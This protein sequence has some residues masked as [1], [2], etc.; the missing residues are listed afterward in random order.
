MTGGVPNEGTVPTEDGLS[1]TWTPPG[2]LDLGAVLAPL[3]RG[4]GDPT[5]HVGDRGA[6]WWASTTRTGPASLRVSARGG[7][8]RAHAW[9]PGAHLVL[10][11]LPALL[12]AADDPSGFQPAHDIVARGQR[13]CRAVP[14]GACGRVWDVLVAAVLE[15]KVTNREAWRS[16]RQL[17][18]RFGSTAPGPVPQGLRVPPDAQ[19]LRAVRDWEWHRAGVDGA[20]RR[21]LLAAAS[22]AGRLERAVQLGG[23]DGCALLQHVPG[24]GPWTAAE[25]AQRAW[26]DPDAVSVGDYHLPTIVG[27]ALTGGSLDDAGMLDVLQPYTGHRHRAVRYLKAA[28][29]SRPRYGPRMPARDY[30]S[31]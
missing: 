24:I 10:D 9:G 30:R 15:Q 25:V 17:C 31:I 2:P 26:G 18:H 7:Q 4:T 16:W 12:G 21:T 28:G 20:R 3:R 8:V 23:T 19:Q 1:R 27:L 13:A 5:W 29:A 22:V 6:L 11:G 14:Q